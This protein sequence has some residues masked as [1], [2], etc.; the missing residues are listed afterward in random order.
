SPG[1]RSPADIYLRAASR[2]RVDARRHARRTESIR[3]WREDVLFR[4]RRAHVAHVAGEQQRRDSLVEGWGAPL[5]GSA[6][7]GRKLYRREWNIDG[8]LPRRVFVLVCRGSQGE[9]PPRA[10]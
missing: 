7:L 5:A 8:L 10:R 6:Y 3:R 9:A 2:A 4:I 1:W